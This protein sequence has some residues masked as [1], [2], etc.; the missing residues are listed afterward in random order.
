MDEKLQDKILN[1]ITICFNENDGNKINRWLC[2]VLINEIKHIFDEKE[3][4]NES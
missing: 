4:K 1:L 2:L 3:G